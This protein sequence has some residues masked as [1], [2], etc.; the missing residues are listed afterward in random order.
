MDGCQKG[1]RGWGEGEIGEGGPKVSTSSYKTSHGDVT[2][3]TVTVV[4]NTLS[5]V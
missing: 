5:H 2:Y 1:G 4:N 3:S